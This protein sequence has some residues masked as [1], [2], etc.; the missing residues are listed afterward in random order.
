MV[1]LALALNNYQTFHATGEQITLGISISGSYTDTYTA[2]GTYRIVKEEY[3]SGEARTS[4]DNPSDFTF[5]DTYTMVINYTPYTM[6]AEGGFIYRMAIHIFEA[7]DTQ[8]RLALYEDTDNTPRVL[9]AQSDPLTITT[10][11][12]LWFDIEPQLVPGGTRYWI[13]YQANN[14]EASW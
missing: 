14:G 8:V 11:G 10:T 4:G 12:W 1:G 9:L 3:V 5:R 2:D 6:P 7:G 13:A